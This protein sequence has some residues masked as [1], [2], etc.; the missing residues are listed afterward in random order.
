MVQTKTLLQSDKN[1]ALLTEFRIH[2]PICSPS[3]SETVSGRYFHNIKSQLEVPPAQLQG[4]ATG[5]VDGTLY[6]NESFGVHLRAKKGYQVGIFGKANFNTCDGFDRWFQGVVCGYG[7]SYQDNEAPNFHYKAGPDDYGTDLLV[8]KAIEWIKRPNVS[9][10]D[11]GS[12]PFFVYYAPHCPHTPAVPSKKYEDAC[13]NVTSPRNP[14]YNWTHPSFHELVA[15]QPPLTSDDE[16]L[17][18]DLARRRCQTLLSV[19]DA[20]ARLVTTVKDLGL[21]NNTYFVI[22]SDHGYNLGHHRIPSNKFLL[23]DHATRIPMVVRGPGIRSGLNPVLGTNVDFAPT[24]LAM[25]GIPTPPTMDGRSLLSQLIGT[26]AGQSEGHGDDQDEDERAIAELPLATRAQLQR[27]RAGLAQRPWRQEQFHQYYNQGGPS[28]V[29]PQ[30]CPQKVGAFKPCEGWSPG[31]TT[32]PTQQ[33][34]DLSEPRFPRDD[35]LVATVRP[36]DDYS[37][38]YIGLHVLD[39]TL[40]SGHYKYAEYQYVCSPEQISAKDCF[41]EVDMYQLFDLKNDPYEL[42]NVYNTTAPEIKNALAQKLRAWYP[43]QGTSCP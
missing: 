37:N 29:H 8:D 23:Y 36:L 9:G 25:A 2:T 21:W 12:R 13:P 22:S 20:H 33:P 24:W 30:Q 27:E 38:T 5:H 42:I 16:I 26:P 28:P 40:G 4:A 43:C 6:R 41:S 39:P 32:N 3:R 31:S 18:D 14:A 1:G 7:G 15:Y 10:E 35:G 19:D 11:S 17:I 34:G